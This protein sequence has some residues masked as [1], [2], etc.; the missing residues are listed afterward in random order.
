[1]FHPARS[2]WNLLRVKRALP[3][4]LFVLALGSA[5]FAAK[6]A[7]ST[8]PTPTAAPAPAVIALREMTTLLLFTSEI[9]I[10]LPPGVELLAL[11]IV[12]PSSVSELAPLAITAVDGLLTTVTFA[13]LSRSQVVG[14]KPP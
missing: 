10:E 9:A 7:D 1:M 11:R 14:L 13:G 3:V 2:F 12:R 5:R 6:A 4:L 8:S